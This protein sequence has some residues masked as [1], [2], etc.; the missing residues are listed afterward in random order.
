M[1]VSGPDPRRVD[2]RARD[3]VEARV[4]AEETH[5]HLCGG[6]VDKTLPAGMPSSPEV[7]EI[8][9]VSLG[10]DPLDRD[11]CRLAHKSCN[12]R[13]GNMTVAEFRRRYIRSQPLVT[14]RAW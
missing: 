10:G 3:A 7:D 6:K 9:P 5:C 12:A 11:N 8:I 1:P 2:Q 14:S 4:R 13:R